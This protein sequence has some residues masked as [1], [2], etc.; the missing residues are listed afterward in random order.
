[1]DGKRI[2]AHLLERFGFEYPKLRDLIHVEGSPFPSGGKNP[3]SLE[4]AGQ[5]LFVV[6]KNEDPKQQRRVSNEGDNKQK[7]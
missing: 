4:L 6:N 3:I 7:N 2:Y 5:Y 1:M